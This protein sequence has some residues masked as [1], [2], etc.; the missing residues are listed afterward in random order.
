MSDT[1]EI[2]ELLCQSAED[3]ISA[4]GDLNTQRQNLGQAWPIDRKLWSSLAD[5][6]WLGLA[7]T[8]RLGGSQMHVNVAAPLC[9]VLGRHLFD[10]PFI[11]AA[12]LPAMVLNAAQ[13]KQAQSLADG[14]LSGATHLCLAWQE[15]VECSELEVPKTRVENGRLIGRKMFVAGLEDDSVMLVYAA[16]A[17]QTAVF[18]LAANT[19]GVSIKRFATAHGSYSQVEFSDV[20]LDD[21]APLLSGALA[22][23]AVRRAISFGRVAVSA[24]LAGIARS[25]LEQTIEYVNQRVQF[26]RPIG[27]FQSVKHRC[28]D[29]AIQ[30]EM[31]DVAWRNA[32]DQ[33]SVGCD[34]DFNGDFNDGVYQASQYA[35][36]ARCSDVARQV[37]KEAVQLH[38]AMGFTEECNVGLHF[39]AA[40][41]YASWLGTPVFMRRQF[42][43]AG[44]S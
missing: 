41:Q 25:C 21:A 43:S 1:S 22:T 19:E 6:G 38:G 30:L 8:E 42:I 17:G 32:A 40:M 29:M 36:K 10:Q 3:F 26:G 20:P 12:L 37:C 34:D 23:R 39:R 16:H 11:A 44:G 5:L 9:E 4:H 28:V 33:M 7:L 35:A 13:N 15:A 27:S 24:Q 18:A 2:A 14:L 31:A